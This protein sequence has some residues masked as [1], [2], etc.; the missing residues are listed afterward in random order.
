MVISDKL[1]CIFVR[2]PKNASTS[3]E[4]AL[5]NEDPDCI[6]GDDSNPPYGHELASQVRL[7]AGEERWNSYFKFAFVREPKERFISSFVYNA[8]YT[9]PDQHNLH[10]LLNDEH[11][12][13]RSPNKVINKHM[14]AQFHVYDKH[15]SQPRNAYQQVHWLN[16]ELWI[17]NVSNLKAHWSYVCKQI[18]VDLPLQRT[19]T[20]TSKQWTIDK[21]T[22]LLLALYYKEDFTLYKSIWKN[23]I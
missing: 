6:R 17:G 12:L 16:E 1:K 14:F 3:M 20:T 23:T 10:W 18:D 22:G 11:H 21:E 4:E 5:I 15:W 19:N 2:V 7:I 9:F 13:E 8:D